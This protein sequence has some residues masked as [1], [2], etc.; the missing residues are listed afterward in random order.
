[1]K[2]A[3]NIKTDDWNRIINGLVKEGWRITSKY[4]GYDR[5]IDFDFLI[6]RNGSDKM[7]FGWDN[8][9]EGEIK[10]S[11]R[12]FAQ[13]TKK[14]DIDFTFGKPNNLKQSVIILTRLQKLIYSFSRIKM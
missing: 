6:L 10:C 4:D 2:V 3:I 1:M 13:L 7:F 5:G 9:L 14:F 12:L 11:D 8:W